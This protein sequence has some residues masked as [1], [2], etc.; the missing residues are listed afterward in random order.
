[1]PLDA[2]GTWLSTR[3]LERRLTGKTRLIM[4]R[5]GDGVCWS[6]ASCVAAVAAGALVC[7]LVGV[8]VGVLAAGGHPENVP[9]RLVGPAPA[10]AQVKH[11]AAAPKAVTV[12][13]PGPTT[14]VTA[15]P[16]V[17]TVTVTARQPASTVTVTETVT[18]PTTSAVGTTGT[19]TP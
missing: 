1:V 5:P 19:A 13:M 3:V 2:F 15:A 9:L 8:W 16:R 18:T 6:R 14:T 17:K 10:Q 4:Q 12:M 11:K 7:L